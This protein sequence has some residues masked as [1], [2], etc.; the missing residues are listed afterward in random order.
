MASDSEQPPSNDG[1]SHYDL[2][3]AYLEMGLFEDALLE[4]SM[5]ERVPELACRVGLTIGAVHLEQGHV[6]R[7]VAAWRRALMGPGRTPE[8]ERRLAR[9]LAE[10]GGEDA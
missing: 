2:A 7:A 4:L 5:A 3:V 1:Q 8:L 10:H 9:L 6:E